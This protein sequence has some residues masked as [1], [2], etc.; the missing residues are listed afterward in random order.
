MTSID[1]LG[2]LLGVNRHESI[3]GTILSHIQVPGILSG[4]LSS[5][6]SALIDGR[7]SESFF[8]KVSLLYTSLVSSGS[9]SADELGFAGHGA[10]TYISY[11]NIV[12]AGMM[13]DDIKKILTKYENTWL[14]LSEQAN[15]GMTPDEL[16][17]YNMGRNILT[18]SLTDVEKYATDYP[19]FRD[20]ADLGMSGSLQYWSVE[21][22]RA[23]ILSLTKQLTTDLAGTGMT[24]ADSL[25]LAKNLETVSFSG[26]IGYDP[27][28]PRI[29][30]IDGALSV[31]GA[32]VAEIMVSRG[33]DGGQIR[34]SNSVEQLSMELNYGNKDDRYTF[35]V[36]VRQAD[37]EMG[38]LNGYIDY[39]GG[40]L[41]EL[42]LEGSAQGITV[43][44]RH[45]VDGDQFS[46][47]LSAVIGTLE[48]SGVTG[49]GQ[50]KSLK[51]NGMAPFGSL[52][53]DL[54]EGTGGMVRGPV[55]VKSGE[56]TL[57]D[58][59]LALAITKER[60]AII[61]DLLS[62][63]LPAH[64]DIDISAKSTPSSKT[65]TKPTSTKT[66][67]DLMSEIDAIS[68]L[69]AFSEVPMD[70]SGLNSALSEMDSG[71]VTQ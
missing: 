56:E 65:L 59:T 34:I 39:T 63:S 31:S 54:I 30:V 13:S 16:V 67:Q 4:S 50:L 57:M 9:I 17:G 37:T 44:L 49:D 25:D 60:F 24:D 68:P 22:D 18:K 23:Q 69:E 10:D 15:I 21:L 12:D 26:K 8:R 27:A 62:E 11:K 53:A 28:D 61:L 46:G 2:Q 29:S 36:I 1:E 38:K 42:S 66:L 45:T 6:Y 51:I 43:S 47:K 3:E 71:V 58:A 64:L 33:T 20:T 32:L 35:D 7:N 70:E 5:D 14:S 41:R 52:T 40:D 55:V 19:I 48:W